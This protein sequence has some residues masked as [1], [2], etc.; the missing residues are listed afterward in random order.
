MQVEASG[1]VAEAG[2]PLEHAVVM[3]AGPVDLGAGGTFEKFVAPQACF[4]GDAGEDLGFGDRLE[5]RVAA[6]AAAEGLKVRLEAEAADDFGELEARGGGTDERAVFDETAHQKAAVHGEQHALL[7][8]GCGGQ[9]VVGGVFFVAGVEP[10]NAEILGEA[11]EV[12][13]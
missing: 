4:L 12:A 8:M 2:N 1:G 3:G 9:P 11:A 5:D 13:I 7:G 10:E 6:E